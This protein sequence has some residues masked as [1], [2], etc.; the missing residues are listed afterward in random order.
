MLIVLTGALVMSNRSNRLM[1]RAQE[2]ARQWR[3]KQELENRIHESEERFKQVAES[4]EEWIWETDAHGLYTYSSSAVQTIL[5][6]HPEEIVG[7]KHFYDLFTPDVRDELRQAASAGFARKETIRNLINPNVHKNGS[8]V[9][10]ETS[11]IPILDQRGDLLGYRGTDTD[12]TARTR[13]EESLKQSVSLLQATLESTADGILV[14]D[15]SGRITSYN[16]QFAEMWY[17]PDDVVASRDDDRLLNHV[18]GQ[19]EDPEAFISKV[20]KLYAHPGESSFDVLEFKDERI[21]ERYSLPQRV[22]G[23][24]VGR[25]WSFRDVTERKKA[26]HEIKLLA[27]TLSSTKDCVSIADLED[28]IIFVNDAFLQTYGYARGEL[29]GKPVSI[30]RSEKT[31][32]QIGSQILAATLA[33]GWYGELF[34]RRRDGSD[35]PIELWTS[36]VKDDIGKVVAT[37]GV[38]RDIT[39]RKVAEQER[40]SLI[41]ELKTVLENVKTLDGLVPI[42]AHCKKIRDDKGYWNQL[43]KYILDHTDATL[44]HGICPDC[45]KLYFPGIAAKTSPGGQ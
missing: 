25:V 15:S 40:E 21:F 9:I 44:T 4:A 45:A 38:A 17:L 5:G 35:F 8:T 13:A 43:E 20:R 22:D 23:K 24:P 11:G 41:N 34:N 26:E 27:H 28:K 36:I 30:V 37:V 1:I 29:L 33:G 2:E 10:L 19:L 32:S 16:K 39:A 42:C 31:S 12:I 7:K 18:L 14:V 3:E 6:Y